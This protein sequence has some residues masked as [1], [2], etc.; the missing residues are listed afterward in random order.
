[1]ILTQKEAI[2]AGEE[3]AKLLTDTHIVQ[4]V[5]DLF[6][7][8]QT[9]KLLPPKKVK[10]HEVFIVFPIIAITLRLWPNFMALLAAEFFR[11]GEH[12]LLSELVGNFYT[13]CVSKSV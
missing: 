12:S 11:L 10:K 8:R 13:S 6:G 5:M 4:T 7:G 2:A 1:M 3:E 9:K